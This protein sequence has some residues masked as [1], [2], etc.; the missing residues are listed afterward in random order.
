MEYIGLNTFTN[1]V[2]TS[3]VILADLPTNICKSRRWWGYRLHDGR[4]SWQYQG[5]LT[6][7]KKT[8]TPKIKARW[9]FE[10]CFIFYPYSGQMIQ[11]DEHIFQ[12]SWFNHQLEGL[13]KSLLNNHSSF[14]VGPYCLVAR[15][16]ERVGPR[17][18]SQIPQN[19]RLCCCRVV[20]N[21]AWRWHV[22]YYDTW[23]VSE[24]SVAK[25]SSG[26][27]FLLGT[28]TFDLGLCFVNKSSRC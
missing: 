26:E 10:I 3:W 11:V 27:G 5:R 6:P 7:L 23:A 4:P 21:N 19:H 13:I 28:W 2:L 16:H 17:D 22:F 9:W 14:Y 25:W 15:W 8:P 18:I 20:N 24:F 1:H 12:M